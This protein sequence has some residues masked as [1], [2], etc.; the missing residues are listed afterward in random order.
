MALKRVAS[1]RSNFKLVAGTGTPDGVQALDYVDF[2]RIDIPGASHPIED[3]LVEVAK[4]EN[5]VH[6]MKDVV[7]DMHGLL[8]TEEAFL[9]VLP[10]KEEIMEF[11]EDLGPLAAKVMEIHPLFSALP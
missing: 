7:V 6:V 8:P 11:I 2:D 9:V 3:R 4:S 5:Y 10:G 1:Q